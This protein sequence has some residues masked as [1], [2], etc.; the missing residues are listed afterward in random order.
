MSKFHGVDREIGSSMKSVGEVMSIG[1]SFEEVIQKGIRMIGQ[2][3]HGFVENKSI[4]FADLDKALKEPTDK[5]LFAISQAFSE[6]YTIDRIYELTKIDK[7][8]LNRLKGIVDLSKYLS[9]YP[10]WV[11]K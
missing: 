5:R 3:M 6:G 1:R 9:I 4:K 7:W 11:D 8:F 10:P 2:G